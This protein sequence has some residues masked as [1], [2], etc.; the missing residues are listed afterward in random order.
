MIVFINLEIEKKVIMLNM[1]QWNLVDGLM[2]EFWDNVLI[3][4]RFTKSNAKIG[5]G[6]DMQDI[7]RKMVDIILG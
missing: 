3:K 2:K 6:M 5:I 7:S 1:D 4:I